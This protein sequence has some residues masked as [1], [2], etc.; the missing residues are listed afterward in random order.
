[1]LR[2]AIDT[3]TIVSYI[4]TKSPLLIR[5]IDSWRSGAYILVT[6]R[7]TLVELERVLERPAINQ[8]AAVPL[9]GL[10]ASIEQY[11]EDVPGLV[12]LSGVCR[13]PKDDK[14]LACAVEGRVHYLV[15]SDKNLLDMR[16]FQKIPIVNS[17][18]FL[19]V[20]EMDTLQANVISERYEQHVLERVLEYIPLQP[21]TAQR[22]RDALALGSQN[23]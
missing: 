14:F 18:Q 1:M 10:V 22:I 6:S 21:E 16:W 5:L 20:S 8:K 4:L 13:D 19:L 3:S 11:S 9:G 12:R 7:E 2:V 15:S 17:G 23:P